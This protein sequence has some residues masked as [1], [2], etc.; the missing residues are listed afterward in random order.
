VLKAGV[1]GVGHLG[2]FH[3]QKYVSIDGVKLIGVYDLNPERAK[4]VAEECNTTVYNTIEE[5]LNNVDVVSVATP[6]T[7]H[8]EVARQ[9]LEA[10]VH[11]LVEKPFTRTVEEA[12]TLIKLSSSK[13][14]VLQVGHLERF[15]IVVSEGAG[16][17]K[18]PKF[19]ECQRIAP[20][21]A[22]STDINV[23]LDLMIHD[24]D[25]VLSIMKTGI[26]DIEAV[27]VPVLTDKVDIA[28]AR[29]LFDNGTMANFTASR[30]SQKV[31]RK[32]RVFQPYSYV[33]LDFQKGEVEVFERVKQGDK[34]VINGK[35]MPF[36]S[37]D[38]LK[39]EIESFVSCVVEGKKPIVGGED[40]V[41]ALDIAHRI[42][43]KINDGAVKL[44]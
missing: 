43:Q 29:I 44:V 14:L 15:N 28:H 33:G 20:F 25:L 19:I 32:M 40:A 13:K 38:A 24:I 7:T 34:Y 18:D 11:C 26:K 30:I 5:L 23:I 3:A 22:R 12:E 41:K 35:A 16:L 36:G 8:F 42:I 10:G 39:K 17:I 27:G 4:L 31:F 9:V 1:I 21:T 37:T 2:R 6:A